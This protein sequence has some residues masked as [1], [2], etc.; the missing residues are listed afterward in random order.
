MIPK[1]VNHAILVDPCGSTSPSDG[2]QPSLTTAELATGMVISP[3]NDEQRNRLSKE[4]C[5]TNV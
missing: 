5:P 2:V 4:D 3:I 1:A